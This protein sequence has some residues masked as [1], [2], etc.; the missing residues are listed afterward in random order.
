MRAVL[1]RRRHDDEGAVLVM[2]M[3]F[4]LLMAS[5]VLAP[6]GL[7]DANLRATATLHDDLGLQYAAQDALDATIGEYQSADGQG[8]GQFWQNSWSLCAQYG[9]PSF[10]GE[11]E[12]GQWTWNGQQLQVACEADPLDPSLPQTD[13]HVRFAVCRAADFDGSQC[14]NPLLTAEVTLY[15]SPDPHSQRPKVWFESYDMK[16]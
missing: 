1:N 7:A 10:R 9:L 14:S 16:Y 15:D 5:A 13:R 3:L 12:A 4:L 11:A 8:Y 6:L 2:A